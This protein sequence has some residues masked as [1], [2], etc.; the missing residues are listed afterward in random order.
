LLSAFREF[1]PDERHITRRDHISDILIIMLDGVLRFTEDGI[2]VE[3]TRGEYYVQ[4]RGLLQD[5]PEASDSPVYYYLHLTGG[6]WTE[7]PPLLPRRGCCDVETLLPILRELDSA[8]N[9][10][11][12]MIVRNGLVC[13]VLTRL[14]Y[15][16]ARSER[17]QLADRMARRLT[18]DLQAPPTL[19]ELA[20][21]F[22]FSENYL[23]RIFRE[24][25]GTTPHAYL[26]A[27]RIRKAKLLL[28][29]S[30]LTGERVAV[31]CGFADYAHFYRM[32]RKEM[33]CAPGTY[34][35]RT[36]GPYGGDRG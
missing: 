18:E 28:S 20:A 24:A 3:L 23:I 36:V 19:S 13:T 5:G 34:R 26:N 8:V 35:Q 27:A 9:M 12:P 32:F 25:M 15:G 10:D 16:Q 22:H 17:D 11:A 30:D 2:P 31:E 6:S 7:E 1:L 29:A 21:S 14:F 4:R 33:G